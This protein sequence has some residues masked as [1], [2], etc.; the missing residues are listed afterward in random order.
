MRFLHSNVTTKTKDILA[1]LLNRALFRTGFSFVEIFIPIFFYEKLFGKSLF[2]LLAIYVLLYG[3]KLIFTPL[4]AKLLKPLGIRKSM[5]IATPFAVIAMAALHYADQYVFLPILI[6]IVSIVVY[7]VLYWVPYHTRLAQLFGSQNNIGTRIAWYK[8]AL[9]IIGAL[10]PFLGG[11]YIAEFGFTYMFPIVAVVITLAIIPLFFMTDK[12]EVYSWGYFETYRHLF[13]YKNRSLFYAYAADGAQNV[14]SVVIW[15]IFIFELLDGD[16]LS[17]GFITML[18]TI[19][20]MVLNVLVGKFINHVGDEKA[21][22]YSSLFAA[23]GWIAKVFVDSAAQV[24][25]VDTYHRL[26]KAANRTSFDVAGYEHAADSGHYIDEFT[27]L[28]ELSLSLGKILMLVIT[29][30]TVYYF[31]S[32][33]IAFVLAALATVLMVALNKQLSVR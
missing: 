6:Y 20:V 23:T 8:N 13:T 29:G 3:V 21:L 33:R 24:F 12:H 30:L 4:G 9:L 2:L 1:L 32:I 22:T 14:L 11:A 31:N 18:I 26:G 10:T 7:K 28:K 27:V 5:M 17:I 15:P 19:A 16:Y 25:F